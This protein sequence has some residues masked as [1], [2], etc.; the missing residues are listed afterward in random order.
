MMS[1]AVYILCAATSFLCTVMLLRGF[2]K[3]RVR[4]L[5]WSSLCFAGLA[6]DNVFLYVDLIVLPDY[7]L[8][9]WRRLPGFF[10]ITLLLVGLVWDSK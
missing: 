8:Q 1:G 3:T 4:L 2:F 6:L 10:A 5:L 9:I 7:P